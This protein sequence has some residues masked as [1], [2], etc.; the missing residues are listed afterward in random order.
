MPPPRGTPNPIEGPGDYDMVPTIHNDTYPAIDPSKAN[1]SGKAI[2][3]SGAS[4]GLGRAMAVAFAKGGASYIAIG[5][6][7]DVSDTEKDCLSAAAATKRPAPQILPLKFDVT[8]VESVDN[9][10]AQIRKAFGRID[11]VINNAGILSTGMI[12]DSDPE[13]WWNTWNV[14]LRGP[15]LVTRA[16]LPLMLGGGEKTFITVSSVGAHSFTPTFNAYQ[17]SK[18]AVLRFTEFIC[19]EYGDQGVLAYSIHPGNIPTD[20]VGGP[21][22]LPDLLKPGK[23]FS[24]D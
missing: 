15:Y 21:E 20:I 23:S 14:N 12:M 8:S 22:S 5:A 7:S 19:A 11:I 4:K 13:V 1:L 6:R 9:A 3:V 10:A 24:N 2:F 16:F 18:L 17:P